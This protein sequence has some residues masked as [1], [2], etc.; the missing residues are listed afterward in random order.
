MALGGPSMAYA[1]GGWTPGSNSSTNAPTVVHV[2]NNFI[3]NQNGAFAK[4]S[5]D[6]AA[7]RTTRGIQRYVDRSNEQ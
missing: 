1:G 4:E 6:Q 5:A 7:R 3:A 2:T